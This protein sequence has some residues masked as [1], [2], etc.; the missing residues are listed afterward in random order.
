M[1]T[2]VKKA[3]DQ[4]FRDGAI[5]ILTIHEYAILCEWFGIDYF[6]VH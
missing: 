4:F 5:T 2:D 6:D 3:L 1:P